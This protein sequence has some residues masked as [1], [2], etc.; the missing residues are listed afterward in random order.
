MSNTLLPMSMLSPMLANT[1][2]NRIRKQLLQE[3]KVLKQEMDSL[4]EGSLYITKN[5]RWVSFYLHRNGRSRG[6]TADESLIYSLARRHYLSLLNRFLE[7]LL[8][9]IGCDISSESF[10]RFLSEIEDLFKKFEKGNLDI[11]RITMTA[12]QY[13][14]N[15]NRE[16]QKPTRR[17]ELI[18]PTI[19]RV[20]MRSKSEQ[21]LGNLL[22]RLHIPYRYET[23][24]RINGISYHPDFIIMLPNNRLIIIEHVGRMDLDVYNDSLVTRLKAYDNIGLLIGRDVFFTFERD[25]RDESIAKEILYQTL[26]STP[27][28]N[29]LLKKVAMKAGCTF[30]E[31]D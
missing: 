1:K 17:E 28:D 9:N 6:I 14:W 27:S 24:V 2:V 23:T 29:P 4:P 22:E 3:L 10:S 12:N 15:S 18:Y 20:Y 31:N 11:D 21:T 26:V 25:T 19:G 5:R 7:D 30:P 16:S 13:I 8:L